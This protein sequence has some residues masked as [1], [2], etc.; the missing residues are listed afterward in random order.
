MFR[1]ELVDASNRIMRSYSG[2]KLLELSKKIMPLWLN[3]LEHKDYARWYV[4]RDDQPWMGASTAGAMFGPNGLGG[5][6]I[7]GEE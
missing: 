1:M 3:K 4:Y 7:E 2:E 6:T 5:W